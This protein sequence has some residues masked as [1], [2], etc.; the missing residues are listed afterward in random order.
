MTTC[1]PTVNSCDLQVKPAS[2]LP[3]TFESV[4]AP[5]VQRQIRFGTSLAGGR[6]AGQTEQQHQQL[7]REQSV[8]FMVTGCKTRTDRLNLQKTICDRNCIR[9]CE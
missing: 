7:S 3:L 4:A 6:A 1:R 9:Y 2:R 8:D 5:K